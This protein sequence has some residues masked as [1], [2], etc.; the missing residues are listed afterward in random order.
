MVQEQEMDEWVGGW[1]DGWRDTNI[2]GQ[3]E[4]NDADIVVWID[5]GMQGNR[6]CEPSGRDIPSAGRVSILWMEWVM[7]VE[8]CGS[9]YASRG[10][11]VCKML[12]CVGRES[13][14]TRPVTPASPASSCPRSPVPLPLR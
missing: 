3:D 11:A 5:T 7:P 9:R 10:Y 4:E 14:Y 1:A 13:Y 2:Y 12:V 8:C 6:E